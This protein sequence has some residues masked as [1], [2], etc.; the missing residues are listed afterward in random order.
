MAVEIEF[1]EIL[2]DPSLFNVGFA[3]G[4]PEFANSN[5]RSPQT[6]IARVAVLRYDAPIIWNIDFEDVNHGD[7]PGGVDYFNKMWYGGFGSAY[8]FRVR[9]ETD[10]SLN[11]ENIAT[12]DGSTTDFKLTKTYTRP[13]TSGHS[14]VR[15]I[16]KPVVS[17]HLSA[18]SV[19][20]YEPDGI[21]NRVIEVPFVLEVND[22]EVETGFTISNT[23]GDLHFDTAPTDGH[24]IV[25]SC[26][27]DVPMTFWTNSI[28]Q[29]ADF[30][31]EI[32]G[33]QA[34]ELLPASLGIV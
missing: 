10:Y 27:F 17:D 21:T 23:T 32:R 22:V 31:A 13:G 3:T 25:V 6:G 14:Y 19:T 28:Q 2:L 33:I 16:I 5:M 9:V 8:G 26:Q 30:P 11:Q 15:R 7:T 4:G 12:G 24:Q 18:D 20:L 29:K 34:I 1:D